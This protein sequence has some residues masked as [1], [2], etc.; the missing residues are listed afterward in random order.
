MNWLIVYYCLPM[1]GYSPFD[2]CRRS[3]WKSWDKFPGR[4]HCSVDRRVHMY[5]PWAW[6]HVENP[7]QH[8]DPPP[9]IAPYPCDFGSPSADQR[10]DSPFTTSGAKSG[11]T[12]PHDNDRKGLGAERLCIL[13]PRLWK[14]ND[15]DGKL[16]M[17]HGGNCILGGLWYNERRILGDWDWSGSVECSTIEN[18]RSNQ[19]WLL[20]K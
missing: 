4:E 20:I 2:C 18:H 14:L 9:E 8:S 1:K 7:R 5:A 3:S 15:S 6:V 16:G 19:H 13:R 17:F 12:L 11:W 10:H